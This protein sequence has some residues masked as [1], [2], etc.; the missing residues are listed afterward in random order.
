MIPLFKVFMSDHALASV[1]RVLSSGHIAQGPTVDTFEAKLA[2]ELD[3]GRTNVVTVN[4]GTSAIHL[5]LVLAGV[6]RGDLVA[7]TPMTCAATIVPI[8]HLGAVPLW[9]DIDPITGLMDPASLAWR[10]TTNTKAVIAVDWAGTPCD[11]DALARA[12][13]PPLIIDAA[14]S[15]LARDANG[16]VN[17]RRA[18]VG[19]FVCHSFQAIKHLTTGDGGALIVSADVAD[20]A[21]RL[22]WFGF[23]RTSSKD[24]RC[25]QA[26]EEAGYK[27][28]M[29]D[30]AAAIGIANLDS[31]RDR[32]IAHRA[33]AAF[34]HEH[35]S[36]LWPRVQ[37]PPP[38]HRSSWWLYTILVDDRERFQK[39]MTERGIETSQVHRR[40]DDH[41]VFR[42]A[43][44]ST[45]HL[46]GLNKFSA[47][48]VSI[49]VHWA[50]T[51]GECMQ[52]AEAVTEYA[53][54]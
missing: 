37:T 9:I 23:D 41:P 42:R 35:L 1:S 44:G 20:R 33:N 4:S 8:L 10:A 39:F 28:H 3:V 49:P 36:K 11:Y 16:E 13:S 32:V 46:D 43:V 27:M 22:R 52:I 19:D 18:Y 48:Q 12:F 21:R 15:F 45:R 25:A 53:K 2:D 26:L 47:H 38:N 31:I 34:Y 30:I 5:A 50:L 7:V 17:A 54:S 6:Q 51:A 40:N 24:F 14:H 29:N